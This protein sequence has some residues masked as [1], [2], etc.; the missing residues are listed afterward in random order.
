MNVPVMLD[1]ESRYDNAGAEPAP[2]F[3]TGAKI[4]L[5]ERLRNQL[6]RRYCG[7]STA[8]PAVPG[9]H[10]QPAKQD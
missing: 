4:E 9:S 3:T 1:T 7:D 10:G 5:A 8:D 2:T 6:E